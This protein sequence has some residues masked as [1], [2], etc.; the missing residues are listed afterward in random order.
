MQLD[1]NWPLKK[2][3]HGF[4]NPYYKESRKCPQCDGGGLNEESALLAEAF[5]GSNKYGTRWGE[6]ITQEEVGALVAE[7]RLM[8]FTHTWNATPGEGWKPKNPPYM[9]TA[10]EVNALNQGSRRGF[11]GHDG[12]NRWVLIETRARR[13]GIWGKCSKCEGEGTLWPDKTT[14]QRCEDWYDNERFGPPE[15]PGYQVWETVSE[16]SPF[17]PVFATAEGLEDWLVNDQDYS[18]KGARA[19]IDSEWAPSMIMTN[20]RTGRDVDGLALLTPP[21]S[22]VEIVAQDTD[23]V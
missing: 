11:A 13:L 7:G 22:A 8:D 18:R 16:G 23:L 14:K 4:L 3:W 1:F 6:N 20:G 10:E 21:L 2:V 12:I 9:P 15:G 17:S 5:Y 19:F